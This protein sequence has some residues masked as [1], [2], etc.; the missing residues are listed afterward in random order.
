VF[1]S[2]DP[3]LGAPSSVT[4][5]YVDRDGGFTGI[6][7]LYVK[8]HDAAMLAARIREIEIHYGWWD[9]DANVSTLHGPIDEDAFSRN[10]SG[11]PSYAKVMASCG[12]RWKRSKKDRFNGTAEVVRRLNARRKSIHPGED[13]VP[14]LRWME[15]CKAPIETIP[16]L[17][18]DPNDVNDVDTK[19]EDHAWDDTRYA[20]MDRQLPKRATDDDDDEDN[21]VDMSEYRRRGNGGTLGVPPGGW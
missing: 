14:L 16:V 10:L 18:T 6:H 2:C 13:D 20:C 17:Q 5:W 8:G 4:W 21:V 19:G 7:N 3:G 1:R 9:E 15:R 12:I 11:G